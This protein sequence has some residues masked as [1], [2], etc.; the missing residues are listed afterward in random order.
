MQVLI[1]KYEVFFQ[2][3]DFETFGR[4]VFSSPQP[5]TT[6]PR[7][8]FLNSYTGHVLQECNEVNGGTFFPLVLNIEFLLLL[9]R[10]VLCRS[11][12]FKFRNGFHANV[13]FVSIKKINE[14][15]NCFTY[16]SLS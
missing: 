7:T 13:A 14:K 5:T 2:N 15:A 16:S 10:L 11:P 12:E 6:T 1:D 4:L 8:T 9:R 3:V